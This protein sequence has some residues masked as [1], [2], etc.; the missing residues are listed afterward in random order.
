M[1]LL[2]S[3]RG[4]KG[5][6]EAVK[7][8]ADIVDVKNPQEGSLGASFPWKVREVLEAVRGR[9]EVS[10]TAGDLDFKPG[11]ASLVAHALASL[12]VDYVKAGL[13]GVRTPEQGVELGRALVRAASEH[14]SR[15]VLACYADYREIGSLPPHELPEVAQ[16]CGADGVMIDT[17]KKNGVSLFRCM[18]MS[19]LRA[20]VEDAHEHG[21]FC[22]LAGRLSPEDLSR[23]RAL[24]AD[25]AGVRSAACEGGNRS[26]GIS[27]ERVRMLKRLVE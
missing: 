13:Y 26:A 19:S 14:G 10:A 18:D 17:A 1:K 23:V 20:F 9:A 5:A 6:L 8:G 4:A 12:G 27:A 25:I 2:V 22:A 21:L 24:G 11:S 15:V 16:R 7:G 3:P